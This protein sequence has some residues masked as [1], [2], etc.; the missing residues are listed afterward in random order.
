[1]HLLEQYSLG[2]GAK[3]DKP[4]IS[5]KFFPLPFDKYITCHFSSGMQSKNWDKW[6]I[7]IRL[8][9]PDLQK[10]GYGIVQLGG[11][12][13]IVIGGIPNLYRACGKTDPS[14][15]NFIISN[16][17]L[18]I[19]ND[20]F[21]VHVA[22]ACGIPLVSLYSVSRPTICGPYWNDPDKTILLES[23]RRGNKPSYA[24]TEQIKTVNDIKV[25]Q[26]MQAINKLLNL[27][28]AVNLKTAF[29]GEQFATGLSS[30]VTNFVLEIIPDDIFHPKFPPKAAFPLRDDLLQNDKNMMVQLNVSPCVIVTE[31]KIDTALL[32]HPN[33]QGLLMK[34]SEDNFDL[35]Y[36]KKLKKSRI[37]YQL[38]YFE[39]DQAL[40]D[41]FRLELAD[42][43]I[44]KKIQY[45]G[46]PI[47]DKDK[48]YKFISSKFFF[49]KNKYYASLFDWKV[50][51][52]TLN[53]AGLNNLNFM[54]EIQSGEFE[55]LEQAKFS[56]FFEK[57]D[58]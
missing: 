55:A 53:P 23:E 3:I 7:I 25:E 20:T 26:V 57:M 41:R 22:G 10:L 45:G 49:S 34:V 54:D 39:K 42:I 40:I 24:L 29:E 28:L 30:S 4:F 44:P 31:R 35:D 19:A 18:H 5:K 37:R 13:D 33:L 52:E 47:L 16:S 14:Q 15:S 27:K 58:V 9:A 46:Q 51:K 2:T 50:G 8:I 38:M 21:S 32:K 12:E 11:A 56:C 6:A 43:H 36:F 1:M 48:E 17:Q